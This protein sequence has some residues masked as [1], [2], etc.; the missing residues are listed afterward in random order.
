MLDEPT[1]T[2]Q[3]IVV[4]PDFVVTE[5]D[6]RKSRGDQSAR[7]RARDVLRDLY[8]LFTASGTAS[9]PTTT[10]VSQ[11]YDG[12][13][14]GIDLVFL[15]T[16]IITGPQPADV[17]QALIDLARTCRA[18]TDTPVHFVS[19]DLS[20]NLRAQ[21]H[22]EGHGGTQTLVPHWVDWTP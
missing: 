5:L 20:A 4:V 11:S 19:G 3:L 6:L 13:G 18:F 12:A 7:R 15:D 2:G 10:L 21:T 9:F 16:G 1:I 22:A 8:R 14:D 17:D